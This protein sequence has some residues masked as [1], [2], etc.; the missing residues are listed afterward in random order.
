TSVGAPRAH[1]WT[2]TS[3]GS[4]RPALRGAE[5]AGATMLA[6]G[7]VG[8][9]PPQLSI[10]SA[11]E[12]EMEMPSAICATSYLDEQVNL[13]HLRRRGLRERDD[14]GE[15]R[16]AAVGVVAR[17]APELRHHRRS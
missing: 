13:P 12:T 6:F 14:L 1:L 16:D 9:V 17:A 4:A 5:G 10:S 3:A 8:G 11:T 15:Q 2:T 7:G